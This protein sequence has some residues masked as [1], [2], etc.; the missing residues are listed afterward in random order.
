MQRVI[1]YQGHEKKKKRTPLFPEFELKRLYIVHTI[2]YKKSLK[3]PKG[4]QNPSIEEG[5]T[6]QWPK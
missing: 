1:I 6:T 4:N 2:H 5:Q 3:I